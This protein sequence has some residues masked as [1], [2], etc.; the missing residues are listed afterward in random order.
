MVYTSKAVSISSHLKSSWGFSCGQTV[1]N[2]PA[3]QQTRFDPRVRKIRLHTLE[4]P[5]CY[6]Q[7]WLE[8]QGCICDICT[9]ARPCLWKRPAWGPFSQEESELEGTLWTS[10]AMCAVHGHLLSEPYSICDRKKPR[11]K[12]FRK[13]NDEV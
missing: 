9:S 12:R 5:P 2:L 10:F 11:R 1:K 6:H 13:S 7:L 3:M 8:W 4:A